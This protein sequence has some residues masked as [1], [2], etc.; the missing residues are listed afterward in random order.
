M[1]S[2]IERK[3]AAIMFTD[4][5]GY[6]AQMSKD[7]T[8]AME[9]LKQKESIL[10]PLLEEYKGTFVKSI[11]DGTLTYF[12]SAINAASC[13][14]RLQELTYDKEGLNIRAG[15]HIGDIIFKDDDV[16]GDGVNISARLESMAPVGGVC[17]SKNVYDELINQKGFEGVDLG[18]QSLKGVGRLVEVYGLKGS[19]LKEPNPEDYKD[20]KVSVHED[21]EVPSIAV[22]PFDNKGAEEDI[23]YAYGISS[24]LINAISSAGIIKVSSLSDIQKIK[25]YNKLN[26]NELSDKLNVRYVVQGS[27][28]KMDNIFQIT[29]EL[30]D[31][32]EDEILWSDRWQESWENLPTIQY[33]LYKELAKILNR[34]VEE[35]SISKVFDPEAYKIYLEAFYLFQNRKSKTDIDKGIELNKKVLDIDPH[36]IEARAGIVWAYMRYSINKAEKHN[37]ELKK[38]L[39]ENPDTDEKFMINY[40][41]YKGWISERRTNKDIALKKTSKKIFSEARKNYRKCIEIAEHNDYFI[42]KIGNSHNIART[43]L[44][45]GYWNKDNKKLELH[46]KCSLENLKLLKQLKDEDVGPI[47][48]NLA[49]SYLLQE[50]YDLAEKYIELGYDLAIKNNSQFGLGYVYRHYISLYLECYNDINKAK[51]YLDKW[52]VIGENLE[53]WGGLAFA[54]RK[55]SIYYKSKGNTEKEKQYID[56]FEKY[57]KKRSDREDIEMIYKNMPIECAEN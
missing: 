17:V 14:V 36:I 38:Y 8:R 45:E 16:F 12:E 44:A 28:W 2:T 33:N 31:A 26:F 51:E 41:S 48:S 3:L 11:G 35:K 9:L 47:Y 13:A 56:L 18:L 53:N 22:I 4:I 43:Y 15:I 20:T 29:I 21:D 19:K 10:K 5:A 27:L 50:K 52:K 39:D 42:K 30:Y 34:Y 54:Y 25:N 49:E 37:N 55:F 57:T 24:D 32:K 6:T 46:D 1:S 7:E 40:Y 23:F